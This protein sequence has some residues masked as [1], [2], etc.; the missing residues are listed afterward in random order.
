MLGKVKK[1]ERWV[2]GVLQEKY[3]IYDDWFIY[4]KSNTRQILLLVVWHII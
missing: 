3:I 1:Y 2:L 4:T